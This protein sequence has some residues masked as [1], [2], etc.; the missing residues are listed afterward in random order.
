MGNAKRPLR[1]TTYTD[2]SLFS[3]IIRIVQ[4]EKC[5]REASK[6]QSTNGGLIKIHQW[7][8]EDENFNESK[9]YTKRSPKTSV[10][11]KD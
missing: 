1:N 5:T 9:K 7:F 8:Y 3:G 6:H 4:S 10:R 11:T 2:W